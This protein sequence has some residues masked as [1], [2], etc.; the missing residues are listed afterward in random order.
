V[1][2]AGPF[3]HHDGLGHFNA[4]RDHQQP[5]KKQ[6]RDNCGCYG[7]RDPETPKDHQAD[8]KGQEPAPGPR[9][10][11]RRSAMASSIDYIDTAAKVESFL[12]TQLDGLQLGFRLPDVRLAGALIPGDTYL[13]PR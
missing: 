8:A 6:H 12:R 9:V 3:A 10:A 11:D 7:A 5:P 4:G 13:G 2:Q 1:V